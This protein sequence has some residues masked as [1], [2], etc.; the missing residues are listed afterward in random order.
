MSSAIP[1][2]TIDTGKLR[3][4]INDGPGYIEFNPTDVR[5]VERFY[6]L[7]R[8]FETKEVEYRTRAEKIDLDKTVDGNGL[9]TTLPL[10]IALAHEVCEF[11]RLKIDELFGSGTSDTVFGDAMS[12]DMF[13]QFFKGITPF[14]QKARTERLT[15]YSP[16]TEDGK[17][18]RK[19][20]K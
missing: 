18:R 7:I 16:S 10:M 6:G 13:E 19:V 2:I 3:I 14:I 5:F 20:M 9:P 11:M 8:D 12:V 4:L 1:S 17:G 15:K